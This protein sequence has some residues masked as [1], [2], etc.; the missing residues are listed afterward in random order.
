MREA[1]IEDEEGFGY[2]GVIN[3]AFKPAQPIVY[4]A[5]QKAKF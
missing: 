2:Q 4:L 5:P 3:G 1:A